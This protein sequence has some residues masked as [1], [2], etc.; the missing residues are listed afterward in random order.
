[1]IPNHRIDLEGNNLV[2][3]FPLYEMGLIERVKDLPSVVF[4]K[5]H[6]NWKIPKE[7]FVAVMSQFPGFAASNEVEEIYNGYKETEK[8]FRNK[9]GFAFDFNKPIKD[10]HGSPLYKH[11]V[12]SIKL[13]LDKHK[14]I[15][16]DQLGL[17]KTR[18]A[19]MAAQETNLPVYVIAP[20]SLHINWMREAY[21]VGV[22]INKLISWAKVP[23]APDEDCFIIM[24][25]AH[26]IQN[27]KSKRTNKAL[28]FCWK[29]PYIVAI[30]GTP[31][32]SGKPENI[33]GLLCAI[34]HPLSFR[35]RQFRNRYCQNKA[36]NLEELYGLTKNYI[37]RHLKKECLDL[38]EK[39]RVLRIAELT[40]N[41]EITYNTVFN[42]LKAVWLEKNKGMKQI[43]KVTLFGQLRQAGSLAKLWE[44]KKIAEE[45]AENNLQGVFFVEYVE[46]ANTL[47]AELNKIAPCGLLTGEINVDKRQTVVDNF[48]SGNNR[49]LVSTRGV[50]GVGINLFASNYCVLVDRGFTPGDITQAEDRLHRIGQKNTVI[51]I[52]IQCTNQ[53]V[54]IDNLLMNKQKN[55]SATLTGDKEK[56]RL[57]FDLRSD[58]DD[59]LNNI[60]K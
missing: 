32:K 26:Y 52:W 31:T 35:A 10:I 53:D 50:G 16:A 21:I 2:I 55:I 15:L 6:K 34:K 54:H 23:P 5:Q 33:F 60:F 44:A 20:K 37:I 28:D 51:C 57:D 7:Y 25:E 45:L 1:M 56:E 40:G 3:S 49:F 4:D 29:A 19:L 11:Q 30:T 43:E 17:G 59:V 42:K 24:D 12:E 39:I 46:S 9:K 48:Q 38:P 36:S 27:M 41:A 58:I 13:I 18:T 47:Q 14:I 22:H 8:R